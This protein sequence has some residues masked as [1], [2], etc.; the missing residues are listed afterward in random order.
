MSNCPK[1]GSKLQHI[2]GQGWYC[3]KHGLV[4]EERSS[5]RNVKKKR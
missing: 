5:K 3:C 4:R 2:K 1:C